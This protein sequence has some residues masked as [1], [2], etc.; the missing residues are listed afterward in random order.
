M[1]EVSR[2]LSAVEQGDPHAAAE[3]L[4]LVYKEL[5]ELAA[6]EAGPGETRADARCNGARA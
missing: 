5:R 3:L 2:I 6:A 4:P 1:S